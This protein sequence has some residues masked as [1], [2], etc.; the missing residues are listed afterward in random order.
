MIY[1]YI[2]YLLSRHKHYY[3]F[4]LSLH[5]SLVFVKIT[6]LYF[7]FLIFRKASFFYYL[8]L[9]FIIIKTQSAICRP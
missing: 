2:L 3:N 9:F 1:K 8:N 7:P 6:N 5:L 4:P